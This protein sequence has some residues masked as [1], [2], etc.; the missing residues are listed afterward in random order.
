MKIPVLD[1]ALQTYREYP[2]A[3]IETVKNE[4]YLY[5]I[6]CVNL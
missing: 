1:L 2:G 4:P 6:D 5:L 3:A